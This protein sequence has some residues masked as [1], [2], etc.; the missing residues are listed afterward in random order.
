MILVG[1]AFTETVAGAASTVFDVA[2]RDGW[3]RDASAASGSGFRVTRPVSTLL[4]H[5]IIEEDVAFGSKE[6]DKLRITDVFHSD[7]G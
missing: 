2:A 7:G 1:A 4:R 5:P 6:S 3:L